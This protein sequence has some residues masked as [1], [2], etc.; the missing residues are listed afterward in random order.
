MVITTIWIEPTEKVE[1]SSHE[2]EEFI[3]VV[4]GEGVLTYGQKTYHLK[5]GD[6]M[7]YNSVVPHHVGA[8]N[9]APASIYAVLYMPA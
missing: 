2:G 3:I 1:L 6:T 7:Y 9:G 5:E 8:A 4:S